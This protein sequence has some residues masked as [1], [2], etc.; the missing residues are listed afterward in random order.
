MTQSPTEPSITLEYIKAYPKGTGIAVVFD[1]DK[2]MLE[3]LLEVVGTLHGDGV[4]CR[5]TRLL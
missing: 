1:C 4:Q 2:A 5:I 3:A